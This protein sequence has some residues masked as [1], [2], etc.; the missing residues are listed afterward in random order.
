ME[1]KRSTASL[2]TLSRILCCNV[3]RLQR[4]IDTEHVNGMIKDQEAEYKKY[5][6]FSMLQSITIGHIK[7]GADKGMY[8]LDGQHRVKAYS[9]LKDKGYPIHD[10]LVPVITYW[11]DNKSELTDYYNRINKSMP[12]HP[13][14][15]AS[16]WED[17]GKSFIE[18]FQKRFAIYCKPSEHCHCPHISISRLK[19]GLQ[20]R[21]VCGKIN[22]WGSSIDVLLKKVLE[23]NEYIK[24]NRNCLLIDSL[25]KKH[26]KDC[27]N[28]AD[29]HK[30]EVCYLG[31]WKN[32]EWLD[33]ALESQK[34]DVGIHE[35]QVS[36]PEVDK[37]PF[38][39]FALR[40]QVW[41]KAATNLTDNGECFT[42]GKGLKF[43]DME[44]GHI[45]AHALGGPSTIDNLMPVCR[46][47]NRDMGI[48]DLFEYKSLFKNSDDI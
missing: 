24:E 21:N 19:T 15:M 33:I 9:I 47:C 45:K 8:L 14:E 1:F 22:L 46:T 2:E 44:C 5:G 4:C 6:C 41:K 37:R 3:P 27:E 48:M 34:N 43:V 35:C 32:L 28:K 12:I 40:E 38:I 25:M 10:V 23:V 29:K 36:F 42:C 11:V 20:V 26:L 30:C 13:F 39:P 18:S 7:N 16:A 17:C 31:V